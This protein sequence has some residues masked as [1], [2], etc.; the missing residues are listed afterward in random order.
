[1]L[2][3]TKLNVDPSEK[4]YFYT[5]NDTGRL[6]L[7]PLRVCSFTSLHFQKVNPC[8]ERSNTSRVGD[9]FFY[10]TKVPGCGGDVG[11]DCD[12]VCLSPEAEW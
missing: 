10:V 6:K 3:K 11:G 5:I 7:N 2:K 9:S 1:M 8:N 4:H 12:D